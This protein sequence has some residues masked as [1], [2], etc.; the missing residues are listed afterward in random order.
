MLAL[1]FL[2]SNSSSAQISGQPPAQ[3]IPQFQFF[4]LN[5]S[6]FTDKDLP[7]GKLI[8]FIF[9]DPD[10]DHCQ[11]A[12]K[13]IG[14]QYPAFKKTAMF[15]VS[16]DDQNKINSFMNTYGKKLK[17]Q[18]N[19]T[20]LQDKSQQFMTKFNPVRYP[21]MFLYSADKKLID[22]ED[23]PE[24]VFRIVNAINKNVR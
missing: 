22:Y 14:D 2:I 12:I 4:R 16:I 21:S 18:K 13:I 15:L 3:K 8:F 1:F 9:F 11:H 17:S 6:S 19:V 5:S 23:N 24:S 10:C 20:L 7:S